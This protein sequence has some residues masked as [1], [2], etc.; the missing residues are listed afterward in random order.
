M[1][2]G[3]ARNAT[4]RAENVR[5]GSFSR[6]REDGLLSLAGAAVKANVAREIVSMERCYASQAILSE[7]PWLPIRTACAMPAAAATG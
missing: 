2:P 6:L 1:G 3:T 7:N 5:R 4:S